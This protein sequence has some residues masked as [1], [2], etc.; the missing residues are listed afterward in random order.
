[1]E[2]C[3]EV[4]SM[5][6][7]IFGSWP[8][9]SATARQGLHTVTAELCMPV[10]SILLKRNRN[11]QQLCPSSHPAHPWQLWLAAGV[12]G[13]ACSE[14]GFPAIT[15]WTFHNIYCNC[16]LWIFSKNNEGQIENTMRTVVIRTTPLSERDQ[17]YC[18]IWCVLKTQ[19]TYL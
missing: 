2:I 14:I 7:L 18:K 19:C 6:A 5:I 13:S 9:S 10:L 16:L 12:K 1:M 4:S 17:L 8:G 3:K 11:S 15:Q